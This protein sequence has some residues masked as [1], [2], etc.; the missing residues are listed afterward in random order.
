MDGDG[1]TDL[2]IGNGG[3]NT[4]FHTSEKE[5]MTLY[6]KDFND[7]GYIDP[8]LCYYINGVSYPS[9]ALD[10]LT[11]QLPGL[12]KKFLEYKDYANATI[13]DLF[14]PEQ[15]KGAGVLKA[16]MMQTVYLENQGSKG[17]VLHTLPAEAQYA[18]VYGI[19]ATDI[20]GDGKKDLV[21]AGNDAWTQIKFGRYMADHGVVLLGDG[22]GNFSDVPQMQSGLNLR[23]NVRSLQLI[24]LKGKSNIIA[25]VNN[26]NTLL[27]KINEA[28]SLIALKK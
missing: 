1:D 21:L 23:G 5:P 19:V 28:N 9:A 3:L 27:L 12:K 2:I 4:Q 14:T 26:D 7:D 15:L 11:K 25:G 24:Q 20:N 22:R 16:E 6:Y 17:F 10:D 8:I 18:P 13:N